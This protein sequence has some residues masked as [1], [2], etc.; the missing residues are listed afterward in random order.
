MKW[1]ASWMTLEM[2]S[3]SLLRSLGIKT[4]GEVCHQTQNSQSLSCISLISLTTFNWQ[5]AGLLLVSH[6]HTVHSIFLFLGGG[7]GCSL[8]PDIA[9][10]EG[11][12]DS[13][14]L[15]RNQQENFPRVCEHLALPMFL[16]LSSLAM[17]AC[18]TT[19]GGDDITNHSSA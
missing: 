10:K 19:A 14:E 18:L 13:L 11:L 16:G 6:T 2:A 9:S 5:Q 8:H 3:R 17:S 7:W 12:L 1:S 4:S 15:T